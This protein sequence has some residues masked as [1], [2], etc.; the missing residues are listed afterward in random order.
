MTDYE[1]ICD[2]QNLYR[3]HLNAR[4]GKRGKNEV[5]QFEMRLSE[6]LVRMS[7]ALQNRSYRM[8]GYYHFIIYEP[9]QR[10][11]FAA[12][13]PDRVMLHCVCDEVL[14]PLLERRLIYDNAAC[15]KGK[16]THFAIGRLTKFLREHYAG[17]GNMGYVLKCDVTKYFA[18]IDHEVLKRQLKRMVKDPDV[19]SLLDQVIDSYETKEQP[20]RGLPLG[21]QSSQCFAIYYLDP[22]DR[23]I[24]EK[25][26][27]KHYIRYMEDFLLVQHDKEFLYH[28]LYQIR[29]LVENTLNLKLN[30]KTQVFPLKNGIEFLGWRFY[31]TDAGKVVRKMKPQSKLRFKRRLKKLQ[32]DYADGSIELEDVKAC[33]ASYKGHLMHGHT[34]RLKANAFRRFVLR[35]NSV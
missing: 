16:G 19:Q 6:N 4:K 13:Y 7:Q 14:T 17:H 2:F 20:G 30:A 32:R 22:L 33:L 15:Q 25:L 3:A 8:R 29:E 1:R 21:N 27:V 24:K 12:Y 34:Y 28:C 18:S 35:R 26:R 31:L 23:L 9:K 5:I 10:E 11:I